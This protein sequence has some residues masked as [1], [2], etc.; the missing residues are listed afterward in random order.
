MSRAR[1]MFGNRIEDEFANSVSSAGTAVRGN[2]AWKLLLAVAIAV[3]AFVAWAATHEIEETAHAEGRVIPSQ[4]VQVVQ[5]LEGGIIR[6]IAVRE[7]DIVEK[8]AVLMRIDDTR[9]S[10]ERGELLKREAALMAE[11]A[12]LE[13]EAALHEDLV[14]PEGLEVRSPLG[15]S[16]ERQVFSSRR[17][18]L[19]EEVQV[20][21]AQ[22][23]QRRAE[24]EELLA[25]RLR[26]EQIL[27]PLSAEIDLTEGM[28]ERGLVPEVELLRLKSRHAELSGDIAVSHA[29]EPRIAAAIAEVENQIEAAR[30]AYVLSARERLARLQVELAVVQEGLRAATDRVSRTTLRAPV[31]G[32][33]NKITY[34]T[35]GAVVQP[36][37]PLVD[38]V[39]LDDSLLIEADLGPR[40]I[41]FVRTGEQAS[42]KITAYDYTIYGALPGEVVRI[43]ADTLRTEEG[44][45]FFRVIVR[46]DKSFLGSAENP[47]PIM[48]GMIASVDIQT[49]SKTVLSYLAKPILR[50]Q[51]E[52]LRER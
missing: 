9:F 41:A 48:P 30:S 34:T 50:A 46:T 12:R 20:L 23:V 3:G 11:A 39:P 4:Q 22:A 6:E 37:A 36:G 5:S 31:G 1:A 16:A 19:T 43:G 2:G 32:T 27:A 21:Q 18:Q 33:V 15:T 26:T 45:E 8:G 42:V 10:S 14:F 28:V 47:H 38:I 52:A 35:L 40:D 24:R 29:A 44:A 7:G 25:Q 51:A 17:E 13:A 49:G